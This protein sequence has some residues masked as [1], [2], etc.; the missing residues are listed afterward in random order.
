MNAFLARNETSD[1]SQYFYI[2]LESTILPPKRGFEFA[3][4]VQC[5]IVKVFLGQSFLQL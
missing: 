4:F 3:H 5:R 2:A 1:E